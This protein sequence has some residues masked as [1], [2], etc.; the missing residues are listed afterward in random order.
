MGSTRSEGC[1]WPQ[2]SLILRDMA[3]FQQNTVI[4]E[5]I[6]RKLKKII[7]WV[8]CSIQKITLINYY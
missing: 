5:Q 8:L 4:T 1:L 3:T 7:F 2:I 6:N